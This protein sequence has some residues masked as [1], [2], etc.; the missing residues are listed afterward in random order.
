MLLDLDDFKRVNDTHGHQTGD[1][2]LRAVAGCLRAHCRAG[3]EPARYGGEELAVVLADT[4]LRHA[5]QLAERLREAVAALALVG[6]DEEPL[7][8]TVSVGVATLRE[9]APTKAALIAAADAALYD[10]KASGKNRVCLAPLRPA[11]AGGDASAAAAVRRG[12]PRRR[13][14][15]RPARAASSSCTTSRRSRSRIAASW[16]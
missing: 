3:D 8:I 5:A 10:A 1:M 13:A 7:P 16:V 9:T 11:G 12:R 4:E 6:P 2:V 14:G 15:P